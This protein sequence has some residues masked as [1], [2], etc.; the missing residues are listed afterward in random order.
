MNLRR[1][2]PWALLAVVAL[3]AVWPRTSAS[4]TPSAAKALAAT[5]NK[6]KCV[7]RALLVGVDDYVELSDLRFSGNDVDLMRDRLLKLGFKPE[8]IVSMK[9]GGPAAL[10]PTKRNIE[11]ELERLF[12]DAGPEDIVFVMLSGHGFQTAD[13]GGYETYVGFAPT[14]ATRGKDGPV[15]FETTVST[16]K[17]FDDLQKCKAKFKWALVDACRESVGE[18]SLVDPNWVPMNAP[19]GVIAMQSC[20]A[21]ELSYEDEKKKHGVFVYYFAESLNVDAD[22]DGFVTLLEAFQRAKRLTVERTTSDRRQFSQAQTPYCSGDFTDF[23]L[24]KVEVKPPVETPPGPENVEEVAEPPKETDAT[25]PEPPKQTGPENGE[26]IVEPPGTDWGAWGIYGLAL[27]VPPAIFLGV[28]GVP[29]GVGLMIG[30]WITGESE[31]AVSV[32]LGSVLLLAALFLF[33]YIGGWKCGEWWF[34]FKL[35]AYSYLT[36]STVGGGIGGIVERLNCKDEQTAWVVR[37]VLGVPTYLAC[38]KLG[39]MWVW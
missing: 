26:V 31:S 18:K 21:K 4:E 32:T 15:D 33:F 29:F 37:L 25:Q 30:D 36:L 20:A 11:R 16:S 3:T 2:L 19:A 7:R 9:D 17:L 5:P 10:A 1:F 12:D 6:K 35:L 24:T 38:A 13:Y 22:G 8:N 34:L 23:V 39:A 14:D 28:I 27:L